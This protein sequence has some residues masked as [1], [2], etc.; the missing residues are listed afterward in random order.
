[1]M[2]LLTGLVALP[3]TVRAADIAVAKVNGAVI[4]ER[5]LDEAM[6]QLMPRTFFHGTS[7]PQRRAEYREKALEALIK[8]ELQYQDA[9]A[10][11]IK[12]DSGQV[13]EQLKQVRDS[14]K[15]SREYHY[16]LERTRITEGQL[17]ERIEKRLIVR[18]AVKRIS[19]ES[20]RMEEKAVQAYYQDHRDKFQEPESA[21]VRVI[22][23]KD[24]K[25]ADAILGKLRA[26]ADFSALAMEL[27]EDDYRAKGG[28]IGVI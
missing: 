18:T 21:R 28:D 8:Q 5:N 15:T 17:K 25:K 3:Q 22:S 2:L 23:T 12:A 1:M 24:A 6:E 9:L 16:W 11:G 14:F 19:E 7:D 26:G 20:A 4:T 13:K 27:S 10:R